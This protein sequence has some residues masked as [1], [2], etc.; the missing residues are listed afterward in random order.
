MIPR[1]NTA[2][3]APVLEKKSPKNAGIILKSAYFLFYGSVS[4]LIAL[5]SLLLI[6]AL[7]SLLS[8]GTVFGIMISEKLTN[9]GVAVILLIMYTVIVFPLKALRHRFSPH[10][11]YSLYGTQPTAKYGDATLW[12]ALFILLA[13]FVS[14]HQTEI[15]A[16]LGNFPDWWRNFVDTIG[17]WFY[18]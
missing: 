1:R 2:Y 6:F 9:W 14:E 5:I 11:E 10:K 8:V 15:S 18:R 12:L 3:R 4:G 7:A 17:P 13:W 16:S